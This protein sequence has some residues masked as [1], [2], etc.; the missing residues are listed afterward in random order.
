M[1]IDSFSHVLSFYFCYV[2]VGIESM[3]NCNVKNYTKFVSFF[4]YEL[5]LL[6]WIQTHDKCWGGIFFKIQKKEKNS[7][8]NCLLV[9][10]KDEQLEDQMFYQQS[11]RA[12]QT[13]WNIFNL[14][15]TDKSSIIHKILVS[16]DNIW[17]PVWMGVLFTTQH[18]DTIN[19]SNKHK[20]FLYE[21]NQYLVRGTLGTLDKAVLL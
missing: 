10:M 13:L 9:L 19:Y 8:D 18:R 6:V 17:G 7:F 14:F 16:V 5:Y 2:F 12:W 3:C 15:E 21:V 4:F 20:H 11:N 1:R